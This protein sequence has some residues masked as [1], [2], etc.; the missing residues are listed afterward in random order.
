M[1]Y[2]PEYILWDGM[3]GRCK[4]GAKN[5]GN[6]Y[7]A[8]GITV[9]DR[10]TSFE[11]FYAD[12][13]PRP[14]PTHTIERI[15]N[16]A[17]YSPENC[18]WATRK[19]QARNMR[20]NRRLEIDGRVLCISEWAEVVGVKPYVISWRL[21]KNWTDREAVYGRGSSAVIPEASREPGNRGTVWAR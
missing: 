16:D 14:S 18:R 1:R 9:C 10:W 5:S 6:N 15:D 11:N 20:R 7:F 13:G 12:M 17:G 19:E 2:S 3:R 8:R 21:R 4:A